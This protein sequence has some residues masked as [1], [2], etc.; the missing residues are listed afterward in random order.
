MVVIKCQ[1]CFKVF[2]GDSF[3]EV[4]K[5]NNLEQRGKH[6]FCDCK[7]EKK[8]KEVKPVEEKKEE[9]KEDKKKSFFDK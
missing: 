7:P 2:K 3:S 9:I 6:Y 8:K 4:V 1:K 5:E